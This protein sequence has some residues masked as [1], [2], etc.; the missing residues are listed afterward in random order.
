VPSSFAGEYPTM[1]MRVIAILAP[2]L[3]RHSYRDVI[4]VEACKSSEKVKKKYADT[5]K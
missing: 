2:F 3:S 5:Y 4:T 1:S